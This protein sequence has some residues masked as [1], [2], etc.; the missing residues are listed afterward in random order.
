MTKTIDNRDMTPQHR[1]L[2]TT[3]TT[4]LIVAFMV[5][6]AFGQE[7]KAQP[8]PDTPLSLYR[9]KQA[10]ILTVI[11][12]FLP[13]KA[14]F[15]QPERFLGQVFILGN[16][17]FT[18]FRV[19]VDPH[20]QISLPLVGLLTVEGLD[21]PQAADRVA[22]KLRPILGEVA[23]SVTVAEFRETD[24]YILGAVEKPGAYAFKRKPTLLKLLA[25]AGGLT[26]QAD[27]AKIQIIRES[28]GTTLTVKLE[29]FRWPTPQI[30]DWALD[31]EDVVIVPQR[32][33]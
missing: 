20:G 17:A 19:T 9:I 23:I 11:S 8:E 10:D 12:P 32:G 3:T 33:R 4:L 29:D 7:L 1:T 16:R 18:T 30:R 5:T 14:D 31:P 26:T 25:A 24:I 6:T 15:E 22:Q 21:C 13:E 2:W 28:V 27:T